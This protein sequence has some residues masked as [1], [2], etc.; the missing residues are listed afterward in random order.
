MKSI[1]AVPNTDRTY[2]ATRSSQTGATAV[3]EYTSFLEWRAAFDSPVY[4]HVTG[5][6]DAGTHDEA[7]V[8]A[9][10]KLNHMEKMYGEGNTT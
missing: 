7:V 1:L 8:E 6:F 9:N 5:L 2:W 3:H 4:K 10:R